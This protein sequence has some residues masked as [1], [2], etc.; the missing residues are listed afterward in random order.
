MQHRWMTLGTSGMTEEQAKGWAGVAGTGPGIRDEPLDVFFSAVVCVVCQENYGE[1]LP[2]CLG[3]PSDDQ[4]NEHFWQ[5]FFTH[6][7]SED[8]AAA[9]A[10][11]DGDMALGLPESIA[12][13]CVLC[14]QDADTADA[15]CAVRT[16]WT[17]DSEI[18]LD[19]SDFTGVVPLFEP[20]EDR[21]LPEGRWLIKGVLLRVSWGQNPYDPHPPA[22]CLVKTSDAMVVSGVVRRDVADALNL[23]NRDDDLVGS[24]VLLE[25]DFT[26]YPDGS[27]SYANGIL[28]VIDGREEPK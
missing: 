28:R 22:R 17:K 12:V 19:P 18:D 26:I 5:A 24:S 4:P 11:P 2:G 16:F 6:P 13:L 20:S 7:V 27:C 3:P 8:Q 10:D 21:P 25:G 23:W 9:W 1:A 14:G 15:E